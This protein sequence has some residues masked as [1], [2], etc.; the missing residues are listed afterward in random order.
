MEWIHPLDDSVPSTQVTVGLPQ[1]SVAVA[2]A[3]VGMEVGLHP[4]L[5]L[6]GQRVKEGFCV[7]TVH[8]KV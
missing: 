5:E 7:S 2:V 1:A 6:E 8:V 4:R 3:Q